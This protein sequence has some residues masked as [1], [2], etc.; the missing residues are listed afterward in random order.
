MYLTDILYIKLLK[1]ILYV[2]MYK[3]GILCCQMMNGHKKII[4]KK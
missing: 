3:G 1:E 2:Y 4:W